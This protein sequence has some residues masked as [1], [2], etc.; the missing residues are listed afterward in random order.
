M[1]DEEQNPTADTLNTETEEAAG[2]ATAVADAPAPP[3]SAEPKYGY[4]WGTGRR[5][6]AVARVRIRP[7]EGKF[8]INKDREIE[9]YFTEPQDRN[10]MRAPLEATDTLGRI[11]V[12]ADVKG[13]GPTGQSGAILLGLA[14][15]LKGYDGSLE[16]ALREHGFLTRDDRE[17]ERKKY[18]QPGAR[19]QF[20]F[21]KR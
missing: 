14:R 21:S 4:W 15:A 5:K 3:P 11:D 13:G 12:F 19:R 9:D 8:V 16:P 2:T 17:V 10:V 18:G 7:G 6:S 20:Q 1:A